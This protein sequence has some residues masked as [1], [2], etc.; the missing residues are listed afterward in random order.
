MSYPTL[1]PASQASKS[2]LPVTGTY[3]DVAAALPFGI[4]SGSNDF[5]SGAVDQ[6]AYTYKKL[7]GDVLDIEL[8]AGNIYAAYEESVLEYSYI[9]NMHQ[10]KNVLSNLLGQTTGSFDQHGQIK[11]GTLSSSLAGE[12]ED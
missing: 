1:T 8:K 9:V 5:I 6:V 7:G 10:A 2:I 4:Y 12:G 11:A 3:A